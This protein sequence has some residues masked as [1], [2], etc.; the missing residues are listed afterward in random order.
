MSD[1]NL[2]DI[3]IAS[4]CK[5][6]WDSMKGNDTK[7]YC[8]QCHL[9]VYNISEMT[10][11]QAVKL[12]G[13]S[14]GYCFS[15]YRRPDGTV[16]TRDCPVG[17]ARLKKYLKWSVAIIGSFFTGSVLFHTFMAKEVEEERQRQRVYWSASHDLGSAGPL[18]TKGKAVICAKD[19][20]K[21]EKFSPRN[22]EEVEIEYES[23]PRDA[24]CSASLLL[25]KVA[26]VAM[27]SGKVIGEHEVSESPIQSYHL[28][29]NWKME[30]R[31]N[32]IAEAEGQTSSQLLSNWLR[33]EL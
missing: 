22:L 26:S 6:P 7:R 17:L 10:T 3:R 30:E 24:I 31:I 23:M 27:P 15:L 33:D 16:I 28:D 32:D 12:I 19:V 29:L 13:S 21:G 14:T 18:S 25:G 4:P 5:V 1:I 20:A 2:D 8:S 11:S 9:N